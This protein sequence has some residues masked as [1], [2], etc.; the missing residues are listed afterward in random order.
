[1]YRRPQPGDPPTLILSAGFQKD[2]VQLVN[3]FLAGG[4][5]RTGDRK[6]PG[7]QVFVKNTTDSDFM[8]RQVVQLGAMVEPPSS[9][10]DSYYQSPI[11]NAALPTWH[12]SIDNLTVMPSGALAGE[13]GG[14]SNRAWGAV[15]ATIVNASD[16]YAMIDPSDVTKVKTAS[17][18]P[19][20]IIGSDS[21]NGVALVDFTK[22]QMLWRYELTQDSQA[23]AITTAKLLNIDGTEFAASI[24]LSDPD[25]MMDDQSSGDKGWCMH[26]GNTFQAQAAYCDGS[27]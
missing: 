13:I 14:Y 17:G 1:M 10:V 9:L 16:R 22:S 11:V 12:T 20:K 5:G 23:P 18:G 25:G 19:W 6:N 4:L 27:A 7:P 21:T 2:L 24:N 26:V 3:L 15:N 8:P